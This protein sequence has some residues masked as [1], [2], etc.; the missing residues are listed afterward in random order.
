M[1]LE[2]TVTSEASATVGGSGTGAS[3]TYTVHL[4]REDPAHDATL[5]N[6]E[7][8]DKEEQKLSYKPSFKPEADTYTLE[9]PMRP[10]RSS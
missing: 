3:R 5:K 9:I 10:I 4:R 2:I 6:M 7:V 1:D 8:M